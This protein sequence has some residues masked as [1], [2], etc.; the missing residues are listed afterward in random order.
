MNL[1]DVHVPGRAVPQGSVIPMVIKGKDGGHA[2]AR[3]RYRPAVGEYRLRLAQ[4]LRDMPQGLPSTPWTGAAAVHLTVYVTRPASHYLPR[5]KRRPDPVLRDDAPAHPIS[6]NHGDAD[7][8]ARLACD[9]ATDAGIWKDDSQAVL[10][11]VSKRWADTESLHL[12][13]DTLPND[14]N[15]NGPTR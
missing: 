15:P 4:A 7:K 10:L 12:R 8:H 9:A 14:I 1:A 3:A 5:N 13:I 6:R 2:R 11:V